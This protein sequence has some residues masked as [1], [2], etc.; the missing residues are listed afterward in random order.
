MINNDIINNINV[1]ANISIK[2]N[3]TIETFE[4]ST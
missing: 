1:D 4:K 3:N 2:K